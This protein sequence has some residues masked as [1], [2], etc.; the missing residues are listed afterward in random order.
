MS[1]KAIALHRMLLF[2]HRLASSRFLFLFA[3]LLTAMS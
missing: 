3:R 1:V 2:L